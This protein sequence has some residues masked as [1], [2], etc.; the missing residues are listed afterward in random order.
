MHVSVCLYIHLIGVTIVKRGPKGPATLDP[1]VWKSRAKVG[2]LEHF[3]L[4]CKRYL[5][6]PK[7]QGAGKPFIIRDWQLEAVRDV[8]EKA[9]RFIC[10]FF[11]VVMAS[12]G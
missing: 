8:F 7:G 4:F 12:L 11:P 10:L 1:L 5:K 3:R 9:R 2:T 6:V